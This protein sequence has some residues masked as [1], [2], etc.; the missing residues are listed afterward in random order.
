MTRRLHRKTR[1]RKTGAKATRAKARK[2]K[3][4]LPVYHS[5]YYK[6]HFKR[7]FAAGLAGA[8]AVTLMPAILDNLHKNGGLPIKT[9][10]IDEVPE[11][12]HDCEECRRL[13]WVPLEM[14]KEF[15]CADCEDG[16]KFKEIKK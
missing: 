5:R 15:N 10:Y 12:E 8:A 1:K 3:S 14:V 16:D 11:P 9:D 7:Y 4:A 2:V 6:K 13:E